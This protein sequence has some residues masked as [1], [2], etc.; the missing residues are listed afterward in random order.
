MKEIHDARFKF[1]PALCGDLL[2]EV[3][4]TP[5]PP[6]LL[7]GSG[8]DDTG[9]SVDKAA[10]AT[11]SDSSRLKV[12]PQCGDLMRLPPPMSHVLGHKMKPHP[13]EKG[14][15]VLQAIQAPTPLSSLQTLSTRERILCALMDG[16]Y[17]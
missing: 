5:V 12:A 14:R 4:L 2:C 11:P 17:A 1:V 10:E 16:A 3:L 9:D 15:T 6:H 13:L 8:V 7:R